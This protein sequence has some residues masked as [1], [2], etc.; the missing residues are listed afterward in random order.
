[1]N[2]TE[3]LQ[4]RYQAALESPTDSLFYKNIHAY[5]DV[6]VKTPALSAIVDESEEETREKHAKIWAIHTED[7]DELDDREERTYKLESFS[8]FASHYVTLLVKIYAPLE[9]Y[10][11][12][13]ELDRDQDP[14]VLIMF[15]GLKNVLAKKWDRTPSGKFKWG[16]KKLKSY[17]KSFDGQRKYYE[18]EL[19][20]FHVDFLTEIWRRG[21]KEII[22]RPPKNR[23]RLHLNP[24]T[25]DFAFHHTSGNFSPVTP[26]FK[27][28]SALY[29]DKDNQVSYLSL[30]QA[31][32]PNIN[33]DSKS[34][35][36]DLYS[37][38]KNI[39]EKLNILPA[40]ETSNPDIFQNIKN[41]GYRLVSKADEVN[42]E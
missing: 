22:P 9:D 34:Q 17:N 1:M 31:Y 37:V 6:I 28:L 20:Q 27:V 38:I 36:D 4:L 11:T 21:D 5:I 8:L 41:L 32:R 2:N 25:G 19:R 30:I 15:K 35:K 23:I 10:I 24:R 26:E 12:T 3:I 29:N 16:P 14:S 42:P 7:E 13:D 40:T 18:N 33:E 39:K